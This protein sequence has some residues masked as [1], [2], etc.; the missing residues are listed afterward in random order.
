[1]QLERPNKSSKEPNRDEPPV[2]LS[3]QIK[4]L[5]NIMAKQTQWNESVITNF[6]F[7]MPFNQSRVW[8]LYISISKISA[9]NFLER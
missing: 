6:E 1:M 8:F 2:L 5:L 7:I 9:L 4:G 3:K